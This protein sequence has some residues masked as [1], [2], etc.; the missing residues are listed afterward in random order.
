MLDGYFIKKVG[1]HRGKPRVW[2]EGLAATVAG[3]APGQRYDVEV[4]GSTVVLQ[5]NQD[6]SRVVSSKVIGERVNPVIDLNS[7]ELLAVFD[8]MA[9]VRVVAR[10]GEIYILPLA[11]E[12]RKRERMER[13]RG[14]LESGEPLRI[15]SVSHG[16][17]VLSHALHEGFKAAGVPTELVFANDI[18]DDLI[19]HASQAN[20]AWN[21]RTVPL[22]AP[23]Q[24]LA[25]DE[26]AMGHL[27][28]AEIVEAGIPCSG[29]SRAGKAKRGL[30]HEAEH[31]EVGHLV[32]PTLIII[33]KANPAVVLLESVPDAARS[34]T[35]SIFRNQLRDLGYAIHE[36]TLSGKEWSSLEP[37]NRWCMVAVSAGIEL[38]LD[39]LIPPNK[40]ERKVGDVLEPVPPEDPR[41]R[42]YGYL[43]D[44][45]VRDQAAG[46]G[47]AFKVVDAESTAV[48]VLNKTLHKAQSTGT[49]VA[50]PT[51]PDKMRLLT[52]TEHA[53]IKRVPEHLIDGLSN[54]VAHEM[55]GQGVLYDPFRDLGQ[56]VANSLHRAVGRSEVPLPDREAKDL[57]TALSQ[58][59]RD[60]GREVA[61]ELRVADTHSG[62]YKGQVVASAGDYFI[63]DVGR[64]VGVVHDRRKFGE[65]PALG[66][67]VRIAYERDRGRA[68][69]AP[70]Q[71][72]SLGLD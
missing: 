72:L 45:L 35:A 52:S 7:R 38:D 41:F 22:V 64:R 36:R 58:D 10:E 6:G 39:A 23:M 1:N 24:E 40:V 68:Q 5:V 33:A 26:R 53:R 37:R 2:V 48:G 50:S 43:K 65:P 49:Y 67:I 55:L 47:F 59:I 63:Q 30:A 60:L 56:H 44:K 28:A 9:A 29:Q 46:K 13:L 69:A 12:L 71:Q 21:A 32:V 4:R 51:D 11:T 66:A 3:F 61:D 62:R 34:E 20:D 14:R 18:R 57:P 19:Q 17:G 54:T 16:G 15:G 31:P 70:T 42:E 27:P 25:F 8:G